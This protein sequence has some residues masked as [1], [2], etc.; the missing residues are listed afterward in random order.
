MAREEVFHSLFLEQEC[1][2]CKRDVGKH[3]DSTAK[4][5]HSCY[6]RR[7]GILSCDTCHQ[8]VKLIYFPLV[9]STE[10]NFIQLAFENSS[11]T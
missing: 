6:P 8:R 9:L 1:S 3:D 2:L 11:W 7:I 5:D 10:P 4:D